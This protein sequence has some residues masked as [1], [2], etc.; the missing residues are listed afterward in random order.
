MGEGQ[1]WLVFMAGVGAWLSGK[2]PYTSFSPPF[3]SPPHALFIFTALSWATPFIATLF[4]VVAL[5]FVA[6]R[7]RKR[8]LIPVVGL[9]FPF[10]ML[11]VFA[12][13]DW[14]VMI[15]LAVGGRVGVVLDSIKP[16][17]GAGAILVEIAKRGTWR[18]R[19]RLLLPLVILALLTLPL[20]GAWLQNMGNVRAYWWNFSLFPYSVP[21]GLA[22]LVLAWRRKDPLYGVAATLALSPYWQITNLVPVVYLIAA[23]SWRWG[24]VASVATWGIFVATRG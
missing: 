1:D 14:M 13:V 9:S 3:A 15:G 21:F 2:D 5:I 20:W 10:M 12:N 16:Q 6:F 18:E 23:R 7:Q 11:G 22:G 19:A 24:V 4:P 17:M 8:Y